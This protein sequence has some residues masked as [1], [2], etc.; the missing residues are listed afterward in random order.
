MPATAKVV[1][2]YGKAGSARAYETRS[3]VAPIQPP[4][5]A[6]TRKR[7]ATQGRCRAGAVYRQYTLPIQTQSA[8][9]HPRQPATCKAAGHYREPIRF[10]AALK[11]GLLA[12]VPIC[13]FV[14]SP[15]NHRGSTM[16]NYPVSNGYRLLSPSNPKINKGRAVGYQTFILHLAPA[17][18]AG[19]NTCPMA[20]AGCKAACLNTAGRG[21]IMAGH[22]ILTER[23]VAAGIHNQIQAARIRKTKAFF[24]DREGFMKVLHKDIAKAIRVARSNGFIP[25]F[26]LN[27][28]SDIRWETIPVE[29]HA[30]IFAAF[31]DVQFYDYTKIA[32]RKNL[33]ANYAVTFSLADG[34]DKQ[35]TA[36]L[37]NGLNVAAVFR[38]KEAVARVEAAGFMGHPV[39]NG[40][41]SDL[42][43]LDPA[44]HVIALYAKGNAKRDTL[45]FVRD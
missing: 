38:T 42:R 22:G 16:S 34:N 4:Y 41:E 12:N 13:F 21:G 31:P 9:L 36:A 20:T 37:A 10:A 2:I 39:F 35:A 24:T 30:S 5:D 45:G 23:D 14:N 29:G 3:T 1:S 44:H 43:F 17:K 33:P 28:T 25:V 18:L 6:P 15:T 26:R 27:G 7:K 40:D 32:N 11:F 8:A 19:F